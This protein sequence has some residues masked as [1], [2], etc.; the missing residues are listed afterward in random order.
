MLF[1]HGVEFL[2]K[3][4]ECAGEARFTGR[5]QHLGLKT[6]QLRF[7]RF[8]N[9][10]WCGVCRGKAANENRVSF[11]AAGD[12]ADT[13]RLAGLWSVRLGHV[14]LQLAPCRQELLVVGAFRVAAQFRLLLRRKVGWKIAERSK[15]WRVFF[16]L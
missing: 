8:V 5:G 1:W 7:A 13:V 14:F 12:A 10:F 2:L 11:F 16:L 4:L 6:L 9:L 15:Q 3:F